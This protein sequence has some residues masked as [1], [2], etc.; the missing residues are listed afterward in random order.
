MW[1]CHR[2]ILKAWVCEIP[3]FQKMFRM[4]VKKKKNSE[5]TK[6]L[7]WV[8]ERDSVKSKLC[9]RPGKTNILRSFF[10][11]RE[12][13]RKERKGL[14]ICFNSCVLLPP[15]PRP[16]GRDSLSPLSIVQ[17]GNPAEYK[18]KEQKGETRLYLYV[19]TIPPS[20]GKRI[21]QTPLPLRVNVAVSENHNPQR[22]AGLQR[23]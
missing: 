23:L 9:D 18:S 13:E 19:P 7:I 6:G 17:K 10:F 12:R 15:P 8:G 16:R 11:W 5:Q 20:C 2:C 14:F 22:I 3:S 1:P 21:Y 4:W